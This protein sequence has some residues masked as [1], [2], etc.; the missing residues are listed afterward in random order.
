[1]I[2]IKV[3]EA[4]VLAGWVDKDEIAGGDCPIEPSADREEDRDKE[5]VSKQYNY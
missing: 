5:Q 2:Q 1:M 3:D 4:R